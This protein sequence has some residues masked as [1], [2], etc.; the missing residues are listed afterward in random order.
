M[1][2]LFDGLPTV[3]FNTAVISHG[4]NYNYAFVFGSAEGLA[5]TL[6]G[7]L[8]DLL[9]ARVAFMVDPGLDYVASL[10][11]IWMA[12][13]VAVPLCLSHPAPS[14]Q[15]VLEDTAASIILVSPTYLSII[16]SIY[17]HSEVRIICLDGNL[18]SEIK[19]LPHITPDRM[20]MILYTSGTT[21]KPKGV[22]T[23]HQNIESQVLTL[24]QAWHWTAKDHILCVLPLHH[25]HGII[26][27]VCCALWCGATVE[28]LHPFDAKEVFRK[29]MEG[30][31]NVFMAVPTI[32]FKLITAFEEYSLNERNALT[33]IMSQ[34]RLMVSGSA[35]LP[36]SVLEKW[37]IISGHTLLER[38][39]MTEI[40]MAISNPY[41]GVRKAGHIG[42]PLTGVEV[43]IVDEVGQVVEEESIGEIQVRG[44]NVFLQYWNKPEETK[45]SFT[46]DG[47]FRTG[48]VAM[49]TAGYYKILGRN[50]IDI[51]KSGGYKISAL[52]IEETLR[53]HDS[54][55]DCAVVGLDDEEWG[56]TVSAAVIPKVSDG[57]NIEVLDAWMRTQIPAYRIPRK[58]LI[59]DSLPRNAMGKVIKMDV[60]KMF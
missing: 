6:L 7:E 44:K 49:L 10:V 32:Y 17:L 27:V 18:S 30:H 19:T 38:Y 26:N 16:Q 58:Y 4:H 36:I 45:K 47:W 39:G 59:V 2:K 50:S 1:N 35:A 15:Y 56:E 12:G 22:V 29:F 57:F 3:A 46:D 53:L 8:D 21:N 54:I 41:E 37:Q 13:G 42:L 55:V 51:I 25:V 52:E 48:D 9:E 5:R 11:G 31:I 23:T 14:L 28:F 20:A 60:K 33:N 24:I 43:R 40:G 34:F